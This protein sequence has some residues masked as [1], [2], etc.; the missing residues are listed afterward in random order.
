MSRFA[1]RLERV[2]RLRRLTLRQQ[3]RELALRLSRQ[4]ELEQRLARLRGAL[5]AAIDAARQSL[6]AEHMQ[7][8]QV[9]WDRHQVARLRRE[10]TQSLADLDRQRRLTE[11]QRA[12]VVEAYR[13]VRVLVRLEERQRAA[14]DEEQ[15]RLEARELDELSVLRA[16]GARLLHL[17]HE[18]TT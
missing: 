4:Q 11:E 8:A 5:R 16:G 2:L 10:L 6:S 17:P 13:A 1:F 14:F 3:Q 12:V 15:R 9:T 7:L 18:A